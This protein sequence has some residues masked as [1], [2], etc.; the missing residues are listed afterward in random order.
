MSSVRIRLGTLSRELHQNPWWS[1]LFLPSEKM[2]LMRCLWHHH[3]VGRGCPVFNTNPYAPCTSNYTTQ[4][5]WMEH[6][7]HRSH[8]YFA[9]TSIHIREIRVIRV[10]FLSR[11]ILGLNTNDTNRT[12]FAETPF[13]Y[14]RDIRKIRVQ[15]IPREKLHWTRMTRITRILRKRHSYTFGKFVLFVFNFYHAKY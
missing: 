12:N 2:I 4:I 9:S 8:E 3:S 14:I 10:Q 11:K 1:S 5:I 7:L 15:H 13:I 6:E